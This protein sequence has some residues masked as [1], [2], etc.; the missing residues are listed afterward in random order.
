M[1]YKINHIQSRFNSVYDQ[2]WSDIIE[3][4]QKLI[5]S[6]DDYQEAKTLQE[7]H[8]KLC[9]LINQQY[10]SFYAL[11]NELSQSVDKRE[12]ESQKRYILQLKKYIR[13]LGGNPSNVN[14]STDNDL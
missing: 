4:N 11:L 14:F 10:D 9:I 8:N 3:P 12:Y 1:N 2:L 6:I 5:N 13:D 7:K